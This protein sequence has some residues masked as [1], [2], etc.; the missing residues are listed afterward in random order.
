MRTWERSWVLSE[1]ALSHFLLAVITI[2]G[3]SIT[4][5]EA[6]ES[7]TPPLTGTVSITGTA[8]VGQTLV[9]DT[10]FL[11]GKGTI[12]YQWKRNETG[13]SVTAIPGTNSN[14][15]VIQSTD[16]GSTITVT[17]TRIG[18]SGGVTSDPTG[19]VIA[20][21]PVAGDFNISNL[22]QTV[23]NVTAVTVTPKPGKST[24]A[25]TVFYNGSTALPTVAGTYT[26]TFNV[27]AVTGWNAVT[28]LNGGI[29]TINAAN[30]NPAEATFPITFA[31][32]DAAGNLMVDLVISL[33][34]N[35]GHKTVT[36]EVENP[37]QYSSIE[38]HIPAVNIIVSGASFTM[39][40]ASSP[41]DSIGEY[42]LTLEVWKDGIPYNK[43]VFFTVAP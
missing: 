22:F 40:T 8:E 18:Y 7:V 43:T 37:N 10:V 6:E 32:I 1:K 3:L 30:Q 23:G 31:Q 15:Y 14:T 13:A 12:S 27:S 41:Y 16:V 39:D 4:A 19:I 17:V 38:W 29:L 5:C 28:G 34:G 2:I 26:I 33:S 24:G 25:I 42:Y 11:D 21:N 36:L 35:N 20:A 9:A